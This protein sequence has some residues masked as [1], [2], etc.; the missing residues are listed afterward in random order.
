LDENHPSNRVLIPRK[1]TALCGKWG[2]PLSQS[3]DGAALVNPGKRR[4]G[5][6][7]TA[8]AGVIPGMKV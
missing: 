3:S 1:I 4:A 5:R 2:F 6:E 7:R 8:P